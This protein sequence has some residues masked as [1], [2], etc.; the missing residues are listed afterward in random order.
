MLRQITPGLR[1]RNVM[2]NSFCSC[3]SN[4]PEELSRAPEMSFSE[5]SS[6]PG[7]LMQKLK[8]RVSFKQLKSLADTHCWRQ[9]N[10]EMDM[11]NSNMKLVNFTS[12]LDSNFMDK[13]F[14]I[15]SNS[16]KFKGVPSILGLPDKME[17]IL[18]EGMAK[19]L[20]IH[21]FAPLK[22]AE[23]KAPANFNQFISRGSVSEP[24]SISK[25]I[26]L[27]LMGSPPWLKSE[28]IRARAM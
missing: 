11:V 19:T 17:G 27:N 28:G 4:A 16:I 3:V 20:Q 7:M 21:F 18:S 23:N 13:P 26:E 6:K 15:N 5:I 12:M 2:L 1:R 25:I 22:P 10:K 8:G 14:T 24:H 9:L